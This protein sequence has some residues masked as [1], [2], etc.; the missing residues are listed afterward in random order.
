[1]KTIPVSLIVAG[2]LLP[3][4][5]RAQ[6]EEEHPGPAP[7]EM[8]GK[9]GLS[10]PFVDAW[11]AAD[12]D[13]DGFISK[14]EFDVMRR[15]Q[16]LP[17]EKRLH[18]FARLDKDQDGKL[19]RKELGRIG[20]PPDGMGAPMKRLWELDVN[21]SGGISVDEFKA[22]QLFKKLPPARQDEL[23]RRLD[24]NHD[25]LIT[26]QDKPEPPRKREGGNSRPP[27]ADGGKAEGCRKEPRQI[28]R[29]LDQNG[30]G[31]LS[32]EE[33]RAGPLVKDLPAPEQQN[34]FKMIDH[35]HDG[36]LTVDDFPP[37]APQ[38]EPKHPPGGPPPPPAAAVE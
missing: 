29:Q 11:Q 37:P 20:Q 27:W 34:R 38:G 36:Q 4:V 13:H 23:F 3:L 33:F 9:R 10:R 14:D 7:G 17:E 15:I 25:G 5:C 35:N 1:M 21:H 18:L 12:K 32:L 28:I 16:N 2:I 8:G 26:P 22:G 24:T 31:A 6:T 19:C 30:D